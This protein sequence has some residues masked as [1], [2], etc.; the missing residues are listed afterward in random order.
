MSSAVIRSHEIGLVLFSL[1]WHSGSLAN[2][3]EFVEFK[4]KYTKSY[5]S[6]IGTSKIILLKFAIDDHFCCGDTVDVR[7]SLNAAG[8]SLAKTEQNKFVLS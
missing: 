7:R 3:N 1:S 2:L 8:G 4:A 6:N 5:S